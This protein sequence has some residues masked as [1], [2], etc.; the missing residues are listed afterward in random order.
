MPRL[1]VAFGLIVAVLQPAAAQPT[2]LS[3]LR[4]GDTIR[5]WAVDPRLN[6]PSGVFDAA[7]RDSL[8]FTTLGRAPTAPIAVGYPALRRVD[9]QRGTH[10]SPARIVIGTVLG[11]AAG[12]VIGGFLGT[13][14]ECGSSCGD[15]GD[16]EG[17]AGFVIGGGLGIIA[18]GVTGGVI[19]GRHRSTR[20]EAV[21]IRR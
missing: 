9:V 16:L 4:S 7:G 14:I 13:T 15:E 11:A 10:R 12:A 5:V 3:G 2:P 6:G 1:L 17:I 21:D 8:R 19:A 18:G 20:W